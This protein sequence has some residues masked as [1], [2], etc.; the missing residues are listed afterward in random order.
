MVYVMGWLQAVKLLENSDAVVRDCMG[1]WKVGTGTETSA[2]II[3]L[4]EVVVCFF[5]M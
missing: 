3:I 4:K 5:Y 1:K 2:S